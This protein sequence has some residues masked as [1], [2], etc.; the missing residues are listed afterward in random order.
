[1]C[2]SRVAVRQ[3]LFTTMTKEQFATLFQEALSEATT[4]IEAQTQRTL[5][6]HFLIELHAFGY[7]RNDRLSL[8]QTLDLL[9]INEEQFYRVIDIAL[10]EVRSDATIFFVRVS[11]D[12]PSSWTETWNADSGKGSFKKMFAQTIHWNG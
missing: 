11:G 7:G 4:E 2:S 9:Y 12:H 3:P 6:R 1:M 10:I 5:P 8:T